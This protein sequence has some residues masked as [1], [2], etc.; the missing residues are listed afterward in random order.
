[1]F[2]SFRQFF[3]IFIS[4]IW[5][6]M[7]FSL[8]LVGIFLS[9]LFFGIGRFHDI[10]YKCWRRLTFSCLQF[11][12]SHMNFM[13]FMLLLAFVVFFINKLFWRR[14]WKMGIRNAL[15]TIFISLVIRTPKIIVGSH[16]R[17]P[18]NMHFAVR[19]GFRNYF[20]H[21]GS[22]ILFLLAGA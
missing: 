2:F 14:T 3:S 12:I 19:R 13:N 16:P 7:V 22:N 21:L 17:F 20:G 11:I 8:V 10:C 5:S 18:I 15:K 4:E 6:I 9:L 1:M